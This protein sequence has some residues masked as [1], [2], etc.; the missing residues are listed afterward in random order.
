M[1]DQLLEQDK[2]QVSLEKEWPKA[3]PTAQDN[4]REKNLRVLRERAEKA[5]RRA[6]DLEEFYKSQMASSTKQKIEIEPDDSSFD[7]DVYVEG[8]HLKKSTAALKRQIEE[9]K[10][11]FNAYKEQADKNLAE[12][13]IRA[14]YPDFYDVVNEQ[15]LQKL[16]DNFPEE[17]ESI[18]GNKDVYKRYKMTRNIISRYG[19]GENF[20]DTENRIQANSMKPRSAS[21]VPAQ[22]ASTPLTNV[23][24]YERRVLTP[25][26][27][28][29]IV[30]QMERN[31]QRG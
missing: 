22:T 12:Q 3:E 23:S 11:E 29:Q 7:D 2:I 4:E 28:A 21:S 8:K 10:K 25:E 31:K 24:D 20:N 17:F 13:R 14:E 5:E 19:L 16:Q 15:T 1:S 26:R 27:K 30:A 9:T 18:M 6:Q